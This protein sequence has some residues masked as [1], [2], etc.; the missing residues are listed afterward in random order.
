MFGAMFRVAYEFT[1]FIVCPQL[2]FFEVSN[3]IFGCA[4][5]ALLCL[6]FL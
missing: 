5:C 3:F 6:D 2:Y 1:P 4:G